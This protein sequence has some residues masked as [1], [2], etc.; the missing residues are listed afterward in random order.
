MLR[1]SVAAKAKSHRVGTFRMA[2]LD[3]L[4]KSARLDEV[5]SLLPCNG[6]PSWLLCLHLP[7]V[8]LQNINPES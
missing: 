7:R 2:N 3:S 8:N 5:S 1:Y 6:K 4:C